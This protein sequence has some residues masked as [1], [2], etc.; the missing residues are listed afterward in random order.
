MEEEMKWTDKKR[1]WFRFHLSTAVVGMLAGA[2]FLWLN[3]MVNWEDCPPEVEVRHQLRGFPLPALATRCVR[4]KECGTG[5][6]AVMK[7]QQRY[8]SATVVAEP[9]TG[10]AVVVS[11]DKPNYQNVFLDVLAGIACI[12]AVS[13]LCEAI[14]RLAA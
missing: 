11:S 4:M 3:T 8:P 10:I 5:A 6:D 12:V 14:I 13:L 2:V 9:D 7:A 1:P